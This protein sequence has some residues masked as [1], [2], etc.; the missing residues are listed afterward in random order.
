MDGIILRGNNHV[1]AEVGSIKTQRLFLFS[2]EVSEQ[3]SFSI[4]WH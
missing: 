4:L 3:C 2:S 1:A